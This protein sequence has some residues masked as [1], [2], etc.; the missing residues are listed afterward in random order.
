[1]RQ[2]LNLR[3]LRPEPMKVLILE[4]LLVPYDMTETA[5]FIGLL[6]LFFR[7]PLIISV[8]LRA[9]LVKLWLNLSGDGR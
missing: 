2:D 3:P 8:S 4:F 1:M 6:A 7:K 5:Y 9:H